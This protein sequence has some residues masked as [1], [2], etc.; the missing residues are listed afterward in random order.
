[1]SDN[2]EVLKQELVDHLRRTQLAESGRHL[3]NQNDE[4]IEKLSAL[5]EAQIEDAL[6]R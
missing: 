1:M 2:V 3:G 5:I 4:F 6:S